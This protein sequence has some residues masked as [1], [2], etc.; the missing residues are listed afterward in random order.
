[1]IILRV[2]LLVTQEKFIALLCPFTSYK[3]DITHGLCVQYFGS[4]PNLVSIS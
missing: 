4:G 3:T 1:M 2:I